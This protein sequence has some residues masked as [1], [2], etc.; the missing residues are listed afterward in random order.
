MQKAGRNW[1]NGKDEIVLI[2]VLFV[3]GFIIAIPGYQLLNHYS[4][5]T[6]KNLIGFY[7]PPV[8]TVAY[9]TYVGFRYGLSSIVLV[10]AL[11]IFLILVAPY[12]PLL[13]QVF[14]PTP[15]D[16]FGRYYLYAQNMYI[17]HTLWGGDKLYFKDSGYHYV[18]QPGYRYLIYFELLAF[19]D[20][21]RYVQLINIGAYVVTVYYF[22]KAIYRVVA[23]QKL[24]FCLLML[25]FLF[26]PYFIKN[27]L[28]GLAEWITV[29]LLM[30]FCYFYVALKKQRWL[31]VFLLG[32][33]P[34]FRQNLVICALLLF[35]CV[36]LTSRRRLLLSILF[37]LP[38]FLPL[39]H[40]LYYAGQWKFFV[41][42]FKQ[43]Y[44]TYNDHHEIQGIN[45]ALI[46]TNVLHYTGVD[47]T[48]RAFS[49]SIIAA[50]F[51]PLA[52][53]MY[54]WLIKFLPNT[55]YKITY[56]IITLSAIIPTTLLG[57]YYYPRFESANV[58]VMLTTFLVLSFCR[59]EGVEVGLKE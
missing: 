53:I 51:V 37:L 58:V 15:N 54:F 20:L 26:S 13:S 56:L 6:G 24:L 46:G 11:L 21:Y 35:G 17:N 27:L 38:L 47:Y 28:M 43:P 49:F 44:L 23:S 39:Y 8:F 42:M 50:L 36:V 2:V 9:F 12:A 25:T 3:I 29:I 5:N 18:T 31:A 48:N 7:V 30:W 40:N 57:S 22:Q 32:L 55:K 1:F 16:D 52:A 14:I 34:F 4:Y 33:V 19:R 59:S 45:Y 41:D 10:K